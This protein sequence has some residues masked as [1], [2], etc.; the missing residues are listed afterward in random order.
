MVTQ[1]ACSVCISQQ[2]QEA[3]L[4]EFLQQ[5]KLCH[6]EKN[7]IYYTGLEYAE[8]APC[9]SVVLSCVGANPELHHFHL[10]L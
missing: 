7:K 5:F 10:T 4:W 8:A 6:I 3:T 9:D 1:A 2:F